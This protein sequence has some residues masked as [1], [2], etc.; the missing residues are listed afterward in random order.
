MPEMINMRIESGDP[1]KELP[2]NKE[3]VLKRLGEIA[4]SLENC[5]A[6]LGDWTDNLVRLESEVPHNEIV[7]ED[8]TL[9][10]HVFSNSWKYNID[11]LEQVRGEL[12]GEKEVLEDL[13]SDMEV[14]AGTKSV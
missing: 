10:Y 1:S 11:Q 8:K 9:P 3:E 7:M 6:V 14:P 4:K 5:E 13:L 12:L 2:K